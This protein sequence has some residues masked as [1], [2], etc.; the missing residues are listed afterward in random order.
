MPRIGHVQKLNAWEERERTHE[1]RMD[2][3]TCD[4]GQEG[5][6]KEGHNHGKRER[7]LTDPHDVK[8]VDSLPPARYF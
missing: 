1:T 6:K 7:D 4:G 8:L 3:R 2:V 5:A